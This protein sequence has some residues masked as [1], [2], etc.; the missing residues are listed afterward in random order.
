MVADAEGSAP[1]VAVS[2]MSVIL[3]LCPPDETAYGKTNPSR[4]LYGHGT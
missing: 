1:A 3:L 4:D 2:V